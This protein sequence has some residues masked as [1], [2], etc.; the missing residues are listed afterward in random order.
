MI[1]RCP[2]CAAVLAVVIDAVSPPAA[3]A[4]RW[5][6]LIRAARTTQQPIG[7]LRRW[8]RAGDLA[9]RIGPRRAYMVR[10][11][12]VDRLLGTLPAVVVVAAGDTADEIAR[13][14]AEQGST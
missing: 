13:L 6:P 4:E 2:A 14:A 11:A 5:V 12:D 1:A 7:R 9:A 8:I 10:V 3:A